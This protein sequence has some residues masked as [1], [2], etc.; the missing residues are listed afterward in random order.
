MRARDTKLGIDVLVEC[1]SG[2]YRQVRQ[3]VFVEHSGTT[4]HLPIREGSTP[5][6]LREAFQKLGVSKPFDVHIC[7]DRDT[8]RWVEALI[9]DA[10]PSATLGEGSLGSA[11]Y[12]EAIG[13]VILSNRY[14]RAVAKIGFHYFLTQFVQYTGHEQIFA[15]IRGFIVDE[16]AGVDRA[17]EFIG[18]REYPLLG[19]M[20]TS[21]VR[22]NGWRAHVLCAETK[23]GECLAYV[24]TFVSEDWP[25]PIYAVRLASDA[26]IVDCRAAGHAYMYYAKGP[27]GK[28]AGDVLGL[29]TTRVDWT[30]LP[31]VPVIKS[32]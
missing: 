31:L 3:V 7:Y 1:D 6:Q 27:E 24:Q 12:P 21:G 14:F 8:E 17:N 30:P 5:E 32:S 26:G 18:K 13:T 16:D 23:P 15:K 28:F 11:T 20:L 4:K 25:A 22:P 9:K 19:E 29:E 10:W 2:V